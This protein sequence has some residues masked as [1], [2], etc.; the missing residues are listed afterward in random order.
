MEE[1]K[2]L[3]NIEKRNLF[4]LLLFLGISAFF[5]PMDKILGLLMGSL[6]VTINFHWLR[7]IVE[8]SL[9]KTSRS[10]LAF[11]IVFKYLFLIG[12]LF[13]VIVWGKIDLIPFLIGTFTIVLAIFIEGLVSS[14][15]SVISGQQDKAMSKSNERE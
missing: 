7:K 14:Q 9:G 13:I 8:K 4:I 5:W 2:S 3:T 15:P 12:V 11:S 10:R 1:N 6:I